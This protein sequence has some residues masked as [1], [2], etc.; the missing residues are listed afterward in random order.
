VVLDQAHRQ[1]RRALASIRM[2][3]VHHAN[4]MY[5]FMTPDI[6]RKHPEWRIR[7]ADGT[8]DIALDYGHE[9]VRRHRLAIIEEIVATHEVDGIELDFMRSCRYFPRHTAASQMA[10]MSDFVRQVRDLLTSAGHATHLLGVRVPPSLAECPGLGLDPATWVQQGWVDYVAPSDFMWLDYGTRVEE[11]AAICADTDCGVYPCLNPFAAEWVNHRAVNAYTPN[12]VNFNRRVFFSDEQFR[13][14]L[15]NYDSRG[16]DGVYTFNFCCE[17]IDNPQYVQRAHAVACE[18]PEYRSAQQASWFYLPIWRQPHSPSGAAQDWRS[19][20]FSS[21][22]RVVWPFRL[23]IGSTAEQRTGRLRFRLYNLHDQ[24]EL[25]IELNG[26][27]LT[28]AAIIERRKTN[29]HVA[30]DRRYPGMHIPPHIA[31]EI[32]LQNCPALA[33]DNELALRLTR[34]DPSIDSDCMLEAVEIDIGWN[35]T[36]QTVGYL[37]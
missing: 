9:G 2:S 16:A 3:D 33:G 13:G 4:D 30:A 23:D 32:D 10:V 8:Q 18:S 36:A 25:A 1:H 27:M 26:A 14:C 12:P 7:Q 35:G 31:Y 20:R 24:D 29:I 11:Y 15:R 22:E 6:L 28:D 21:G 34:R 17:T 5:G 37:T 19:L